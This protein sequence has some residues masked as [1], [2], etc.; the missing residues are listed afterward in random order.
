MLHLD[1]KGRLWVGTNNGLALFKDGKFR[2]LTIHEG[3]FAQN[4]FSMAS[5]NDGSIW[6]GSYGGAAH[7]RRPPA[8]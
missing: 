8:N 4:V 1:P 5:M 3:L 7:I 6:V 2:V